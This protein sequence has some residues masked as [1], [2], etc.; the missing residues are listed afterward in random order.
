MLVKCQ[1]ANQEGYVSCEI[2][3]HA[4]EHEHNSLVDDCTKPVRCASNLPKVKCVEV[5]K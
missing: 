2:C 1:N 4:I 5:V 3:G